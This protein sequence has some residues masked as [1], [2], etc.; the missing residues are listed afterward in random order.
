MRFF[1]MLLTVAICPLAEAAVGL[2]TVPERQS[3]ML[4]IYNGVDLTLVQ[5]SR[6]LVL[7][8]G[9]NRIQYQWAGTLIDTTSLDMRAVDHQN[10]IEL[11]DTISPPHAPATLIWEVES[12]IEGAVRFEISYF[13]SGIGWTADYALRADRD[14]TTATCDGWV[15]VDNRS[16]EDYAQAEVR[17]VVGTI[18]LVEQIRDLATGQLSERTR[19]VER[20]E[21]AKQLRQV[22]RKGATDKDGDNAANAILAGAAGAVEQQIQV[23]SVRLADYHIFTISGLQA[24]PDQATTRFLAIRSA[25]PFPIEVLYRVVLGENEPAQKLY[26]FVND[27]A[28]HLPDGPLPDGPWHVFR[29]VDPLTHELGYQAL[30]PHPYVPP[31]QK[32]ELDLGAD[33]GLSVMQ[34]HDQHVET[35]QHADRLGRIDGWTT[36][37][38]WSL[39]VVDA[40]RI[41]LALEYLVPASGDWTITGLS[42]ER[43]DQNQWRHV[44]QIAAG[45]RLV[46]GPFTIS[47]RMGANATAGLAQR[48][49]HPPAPSPLPAIQTSR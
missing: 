14:E 32:V 13:T 17:L 4:T 9:R 36:H 30:A 10:D 15:G 8:K 24:V 25:E 22:L 31:G 29:I 37:D 3:V 1:L 23:E 28:H 7:R 21:A 5:E 45:G 49:L 46:L 19:P 48:L 2:V 41:A 27:P 42:G 39:V 6:T 26:R 11:I 12:A 44:D 43:R 20:R 18:R 33:P 34:V 35:D 47:T 38:R 40:S 16:G